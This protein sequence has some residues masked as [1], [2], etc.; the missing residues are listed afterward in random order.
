MSL[1]SKCRFLLYNMH[2]KYQT[3]KFRTLY[4]MDMGEGTIISRKADFEK[5]LILKVFTLANIP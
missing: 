3:W 1:L 4:G 2:V 5:Q